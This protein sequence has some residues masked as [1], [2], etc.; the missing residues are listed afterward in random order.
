MT[1]RFT[2]VVLL[3]CGLQSVPARGQSQ[4]SGPSVPSP[5]PVGGIG[6]QLQKIHHSLE[7]IRVLLAQQVEGQT[8]DLLFKRAELASQKR[9]AATRDLQSAQNQKQGLTDR[10]DQLDQ[11]AEFTKR[12]LESGTQTVDDGRVQ[13]FLENL[14]RDLDKT[15]ER[16]RETE[17][18]IGRLQGELT[19]REREQR[20]W[21]EILDRRLA[22]SGST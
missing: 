3:I 14:E 17:I 5:E 8:L 10:L 7:E 19:A 11:S 1:L 20:E 16:L 4:P 22:I 6:E 18:E 15:R 13:L 12:D 2:V 21:E 9:Q